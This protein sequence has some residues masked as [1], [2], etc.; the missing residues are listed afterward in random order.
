MLLA[1]AGILA[2]GLNEF[3]KTPVGFIPNQDVGYLI[4]VVQLPP[5]ASL[6]RTDEVN[7]KVVDIALETPGVAHA[8]NIV[9]FSGATFTNAPNAGAVFIVLEPFEE[10]ARDPRKSAAAIQGAL[11]QRLAAIQEG[12]V[13]VVQPPPVRGI[14]NAGGVRM[15]IQ[16]RAGLG[17]QALQAAVS[18]HGGQGL[19]DPRPHPGVLAVRDLHA[20]ALSRHRPHQGRD[21][22]RSTCPTCSARCRPISAP[23]T[24]TTSTCWA[25]PSASPPRPTRPTGSTPRTS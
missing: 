12:L 8:V 17:S 24:S 25:A 20:A 14:G 13:L 21:A 10:R 23:P 4:G 1:Y 9:G 7:R 19:A 22:G 11:F 18:D 3:R 5:G 2:Y 6:A 16:D 15:M